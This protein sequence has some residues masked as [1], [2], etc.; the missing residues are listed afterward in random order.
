M[1]DGVVRVLA[2]L[3]NPGS[4]YDGTRHNV[5]FA[6]LDEVA[7]RL[8]TSFRSRGAIA[9]VAD[10]RSAAATPCVLVKPMTYMNRSGEPLARVMRDL[11]LAAAPLLVV[12]DDF[13]IELG[14]LRLRA[15]G[16]DGGHNGLKS[17][18]A[19]LRG[20]EYARL[21]IGIGP[22]PERM[23]SEVFVL[24]R[25]KPA[26]REAVEEA[27]A[28]GADAAEDWLRGATLEQLMARYNAKAKN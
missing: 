8:R 21:R 16:S 2:G 28:R 13:A 5:G 6:V 3:G 4:E 19:S 17:V 1:G 10:L 15:A 12:V 22:C 27:V 26:E 23:P 25:F 24:Q 14:R 7:T 9:D 11:E 20:Q 18:A